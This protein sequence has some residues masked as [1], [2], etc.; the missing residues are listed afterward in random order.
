VAAASAAVLTAGTSASAGSQKAIRIGLVLP[1][2]SNPFI[3]PIQTG[4]VAEAKKLGNITVLTT[5]TNTP[6]E[7]LSAMK[8]YLAAKVN[9]LMFDPIDSSAIS[10]AVQEANQMG[11]PVIAVIGG[12]NKGK[13]ATLIG[14]DWYKAGLI[15]GK[16]IADGW[17]KNVNPCNVGLV[18]GANAPGP[19]LNS[20]NGEV[21]GLKSRP[22]VKLVQYVYT[23]YSATQSLTAAQQILTAHPT[24]NF[25]GAWWSVGTLSTEAAIRSANETGKI[26]TGSLSGACPVLSDLLKGNVY[27]DVMMFSELMGKAGVDSAVKLIAHQTVPVNQISPMYP[28]TRPLADE[29]LAGKVKPPA[30]LPV[31][32][33][34]QAA[35]AGCK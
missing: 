22:N 1:V 23:D 13:V 17:C 19:G 25:L 10:P 4:A 21:A 32:Q 18:G 3:A 35:K 5:G 24:L 15:A 26:G 6:A 30:G 31:L 34:L 9:I 29:I 28:I 2:L 14:P 8:T 27:N 7:Q 12:S 20:G 11:V 33:H 16:Q